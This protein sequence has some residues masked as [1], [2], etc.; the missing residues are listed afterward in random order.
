MLMKISKPSCQVMKDGV[1]GKVIF[2]EDVHANAK[3][4]QIL[5][6]SAKSL[7]NKQ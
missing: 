6:K 7:M 1:L 5:Y 2:I 4:A 3:G